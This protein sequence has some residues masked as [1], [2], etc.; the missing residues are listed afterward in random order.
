MDAMRW[1]RG[2]LRT[3]ALAA[4]GLLSDTSPSDDPGGIV[5][6]DSRQRQGE[7]PVTQISAAR[8]LHGAADAHALD[9]DRLATLVDQWG[10]TEPALAAVLLGTALCTAQPLERT[11]VV[12]EWA[13]S[14]SVVRRRALARA[15]AHPFMCTGL[16]TAIETLA[17]DPD[18]HVRNAAAHAALLRLGHDPQRYGSVLDRA[19]RSAH[20]V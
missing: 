2:L 13:T 5:D 3:V 16:P 10:E 8:A 11:P 18:A 12:C 17:R 4:A 19:A 20:R 15:L 6:A 7:T 9:A 1:I 14:S